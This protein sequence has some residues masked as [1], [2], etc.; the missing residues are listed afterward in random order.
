IGGYSLSDQLTDMFNDTAIPGCVDNNSKQIPASNP[1]NRAN[2]ISSLWS[3]PGRDP[4]T[5]PA[6]LAAYPFDGVDIDFEPNGNH[7]GSTSLTTGP[8]YKPVT[9]QIIQNYAQFLKDLKAALTAHQP[10]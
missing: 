10:G 3:A 6:I 7:W 8:C 5:D 4:S 9:P 1:Q 2:F